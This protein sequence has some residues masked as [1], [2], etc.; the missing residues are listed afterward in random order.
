MNTRRLLS[1][2]VTHSFAAVALA[3]APLLAIS[4][5][6]LADLQAKA[7]SG[8]GVAQY[9]LGLEYASQQQPH[10]DNIEAWVWLSLAADNGASGN[11]LLLVSSRLS[12]D[13]LSQARRVLEQRRAIL[14]SGQ[15]IVVP[16]KLANDSPVSAAESASPISPVSPVTEP[17]AEPTAPGNTEQKSASSEIAQLKT[18]LAAATNEIAA[19][20]AAA[21]N[22]EGERNALQQKAAAAG[23]QSS[24][25]ASAELATAKAALKNAETEAAKIAPLSSELAE[26]R[27]QTA[28]LAEQI[29]ELSAENTQLSASLKRE[30]QDASEKIAAAETALSGIKSELE[31]TRSK[32][33]EAANAAPAAAEVESARKEAAQLSEQI[34]Q[35]NAEHANALKAAQQE[36]G[37]AAEKLA[38][39]ERNLA[40]LRD[41]VAAAETKARTA[42]EAR[43]ALAAE[44]DSVSQQLAAT[45]AEVTRSGSASDARVAELTTKLEALQRTSHEQR[46]DLVQRVKSAETA[47]ERSAKEKDE[48][49]AK[50]ANIE[51]PSKREKTANARIEQL[52]GELETV[53]AEA[54]KSAA[55]AAELSAARAQ[56]DELSSKL[57]SSEEALAAA[58]S[59]AA[60]APTVAATE[61]PPAEGQNDLRKELEETQTKLSAALRSFQLQQAEVDRLQQAIA[62]I[63]AERAALEDRLKAATSDASDATA[64]AA[65]NNDAAAQL[66]ALREQLRNTQNQLVSYAY[67]NNDLKHRIALLSPDPGAAPAPTNVPVAGFGTPNRPGSQAQPTATPAPAQEAR[68][69]TVVAGD[70]LSTISRRY[71]GTANRWS[72]ILEAN[73]G[74]LRDPAALRVGMK[75]RIP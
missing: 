75:L 11:A 50:L 39:A 60:A 44:K 69:H 9:K 24:E 21:A 35:L 68:T 28:R 6:E 20:R 7:A 17:S 31:A 55:A 5:S 29:K 14:A 22:F 16:A 33:A 1:R 43:A 46:E 41:A 72:E 73:R 66:A 47:L 70:T 32:L 3:A 42:E 12:P 4:D 38:A 74:T 57:K 49:N 71:Y 34:K 2:L 52:T 26:T 65:A 40:E 48:L 67:E 63:D 51:K 36:Q 58:T 10:A 53:K 30:Q 23:Q 19:M 8:N 13:Q 18:Q 37:N 45:Q 64:R 15:P 56:V 54:Q 61:A 59:A 62:S 25:T 27:Q